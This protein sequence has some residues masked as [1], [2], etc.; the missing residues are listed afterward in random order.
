[1][2][3]G[4]SRRTDMVRNV[5]LI[6]L[7]VALSLGLAELGVRWLFPVR[8]VGPTFTVHDPILGKRLKS[9]LRAERIT[10]EF[11]MRLT[12]NSLGYRGAEPT[13]SLQRPILFLGDSFTLG[14]G[15]SDGEE[16]PALVDAALRRSL[17]KAAPPV[18]NAGIGNSGNGFWIKFLRHRASEAR[19]RLVVMQVFENDFADN[20][21]EDLFRLHDGRLQELQV[22]RPGYTRAIQTAIEPVPGVADSYLFGL[23]RQAIA[24]RPPAVKKGTADMEPFRGTQDALTLAM[25]QLAVEICQAEQWGVVAVTVGLS[26]ARHEAVRA[27]FAE[28]GVLIVDTPSKSERPDL[29]YE[30]DGHWNARGHAVVAARVL[31]VL[32]THP[33]MRAESADGIAT[34]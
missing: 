18:I 28:R 31:A 14:Y 22:P 13:S 17:G 2:Q 15:V 20:I 24:D 11:R 4:I 6:V 30:V 12:T 1:M 21:R 10:P 23:V 27:I 5:G 29:Y 26:P 32:Q 34:Q 8:D 16:Y 7:S 33:A 3:P 25:L 19:P 9:E